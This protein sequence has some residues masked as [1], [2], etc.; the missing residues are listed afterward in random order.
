MWLGSA[1]NSTSSQAPK[2]SANTQKVSKQPG[3]NSA[4]P[5]EQAKLQTFDYMFAPRNF[6]RFFTVKSSGDAN[7]HKLNMFKVDKFIRDKIGSFTRLSEDAQTKSWTLEVKSE[8][9]GRK[10]LD[11]TEL[12][13]EQVTVVPHEYHN[14]SQGV[15]TCALL[16][17]YSNEEI[18]K[19]L[20]EQGVVECRRIIKFPKST[21]PEPTTTLILTF[22][23]SNLPD[24][25]EIITG[26]K[27]RVRQYIPLPRRCYNCQRYGHSGAKC[28]REVAVCTRCG[29]DLAGDHKPETCRLPENCANCQ[30]PHSVTSKTCQKYLF[31]KEMLAIKTKGSRTIRPRTIHPRTI[32]HLDNSSPDNSSPIR[33]HFKIELFTGKGAFQ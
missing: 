16:R 5:R 4:R 22:N 8:D 19:G 23:S 27:E 15:I 31:E 14:K 12:L 33:P 9:Q 24:R 1:P 20:S 21:N 28:R 7:I 25:V 30:Q 17:G 29:G 2:P 10:L 26:L 13:D 6:T 11:M 3:R 32:R 18:V